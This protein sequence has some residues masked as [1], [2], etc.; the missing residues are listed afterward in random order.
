[1]KVGFIQFDVKKNFE[2][3]FNII[4][5]HLENLKCDLIV[6]PELALSG[7]LF[8]DKEELKSKGIIIEKSQEIEKI[9]KL[10]EKFQCIMI[11]GIVERLEN[12]FYN[13]AIIISKGKYIGKY[14][15]IHL[16][17]FEKNFFESGKEN[18]VFDVDGVK[19]GVQICFDL[20]FPEISREQIR[21]RADILVVLGN[22]GGE[23]TANILPI[24]AIENLTPIIL[25]NRV[26][27][28][29]I[30]FNSE[31]INAFFIG[32]SMVVDR[33]GKVLI[34]PKEKIEISEVVDIKLKKEKSNIICKNFF[35]EIDFHYN[36]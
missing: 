14:Q 12:K 21:E 29:N 28:E 16:S 3:N 15:K 25:C 32:K 23:T 7:Y 24:R 1:M 33:N 20:W 34:E 30:I 22:F 26:G 27:E 36:K 17:D 35:E 9:K 13:T 6:L 8:K 18:K 2:I 4:E 31:S 5:K 19:I 10:S 11:L